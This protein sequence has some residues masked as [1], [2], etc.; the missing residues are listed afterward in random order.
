MMAI[1][2]TAAVVLGIVL[3]LAVLYV[4][5]A[6]NF[7]AAHQD[8]VQTVPLVASDRD[9][10]VRA[11][12]GA[13]G[14]GATR[15]NEVTLLQNGDEIFPA[16]LAAIRGST[17]TVHFSSYILWSGA[18]AEQF[19]DAFVAAARRGVIVRVM[20]DS[21][22]SSTRV[23]DSVVHRLREAGCHFAWY[24]RAVWYDVTHYD[25]RTHRRLLIVDGVV[26]F[27]GGVGVADE[28]LGNA[29]D[30]SQ[31][32]ETHARVTG[33]AVA[34]LQAGFTD[35]WN[36]CTAELLLDGR[37]Y[38]AL[39]PT[40]DMTV[41]TVISTPT[42]GSSPAQRV[43]AACIHGAARTLCITT[44]YFVP[45]P[46]F[47]EALIAARA[48][49]VQVAIIT[50]GRHHDKPMVRRASRHTWPA[51]LAGG[52]E[53]YEYQQSMV[54]A[55]TLAVDG[56]VALVGS[57]NFDPRSFSLNA[58]CGIVVASP[59][60]AREVE[61]VFRADLARCTAVTAAAIDARSFTTRIGDAFY[62]WW[63]G[64]L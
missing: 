1:I 49:G 6:G 59:E 48:R 54:H 31:W 26:G 14:E 22:G 42:G 62:Y 27:T 40:G 29:S 43:M 52:V 37:D 57:I 34:C 39:A 60:I 30:A 9:A 55:K 33:P 61:A 15:G 19:I 44:A 64:Q 35:N 38:P 50:P 32:R 17:T 13:A 20:L 51:L 28:W 4:T 5:L 8:R 12:R 47:V 63:R 24:R 45:T 16:M 56:E 46:A 58:E 7:V 11:L 10:F 53:L 23:P 21:E 18:I 36:Q 2:V 25:R 41:A 3:V